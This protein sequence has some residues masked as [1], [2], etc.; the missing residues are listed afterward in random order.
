M[1]NP[2]LQ[3]AKLDLASVKEVNC[4]WFLNNLF[5]NI[6]AVLISV[7]SIVYLAVAFSF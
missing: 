2:F 3:Y 7:L 6:N 5:C 4:Y 1:L